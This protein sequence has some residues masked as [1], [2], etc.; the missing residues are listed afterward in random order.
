MN[1]EIELIPLDGKMYMELSNVNK[2]IEIATKDLQQENQQLKDR[3]NKAINKIDD[4]FNN[5]D[6]FTIIDDLIEL[7]KLL[8]GYK[9]W[10]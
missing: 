5:G 2:S 1:E 10:T 3:I 8:K 7:D 9:K 4:M 6:E